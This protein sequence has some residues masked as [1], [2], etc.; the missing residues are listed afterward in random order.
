MTICT[1]NLT[2][3]NVYFKCI[4]CDL[5][6]KVVREDPSVS[7]SHMIDTHLEEKVLHLVG[8]WGVGATCGCAFRR[9][10]CIWLRPKNL[11]SGSL[12]PGCI[13]RCQ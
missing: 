7:L 12:H 2:N 3:W 13:R 10:Y 6:Q 8:F 4:N 9:R 11:V 1:S 5:G